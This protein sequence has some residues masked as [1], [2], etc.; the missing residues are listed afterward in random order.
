[1]PPFFLVAAAALF[2][3][4]SQCMGSPRWAPQRAMRDSPFPRMQNLTGAY[5]SQQLNHV[6]QTLNSTAVRDVAAA[7][8]AHLALSNATGAL[9]PGVISAATAALEAVFAA[10][11]AAGPCAGGWPWNFVEAGQCLDRNSVQFVSLP[12]LKA[13]V[14]FGGALGQAVLSRWL[15]RLQLAAAASFAEGA[16][17]AQPFYTNIYSMRLVNLLLFAQVTGNATTLA[18]GLAALSTWE[19]LLRGAGVHEYASPT[20][21]AVALQNLYAGAAAVADA[22]VARRLATLAE[23]L[24]QCSAASL[25][26]GAFTLAGAHSRDYDFLTGSGPMNWYYALSGLAAAA[27]VADAAADALVIDADPITQAELFVLWVRGEL[28]GASAAARALAAQPEGPAWRTA[29]ASFFHAA[30]QARP[31]DG[32][33]ATL[34]LGAS[35]SLGTSSL[36]YCPQDKMVVAALGRP[37]LPQVSLVQDAYDSPYGMVKLP[38]GSGHAKPDHLKATVAAVQDGGLAL[39]LNDLTMAI[40]ATAGGGP[41]S[42]LAANV[43]FPAGGAVDGVY[44]NGQRLATPASSPGAPDLPLP[45]G[46]TIAVRAGGGVAAFRV[47][48]ADGLLGFA[49]AAFLKFDGPKGANVGRLVTY[50]YRGPNATFPANPPPSRSLLLLGVAPGASDEEAAAVSAALAALQVTNAAANA[51][52]WRVTVAPPRAASAA[53]GQGAPAPGW[54]STLEAAMCV[55]FTKSILARRVNGSDV[56][57]P[58]G[59]HLCVDYSSGREVTVALP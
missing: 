55:P 12:L 38:D 54:A 40:E 52:N 18:Q 2:L 22:A 28:P 48:F 50:L 14:H 4:D 43:L 27:G 53:A 30:G 19:A 8:W 15:P 35:V 26:G 5:V 46:A 20:Y 1:M 29:R 13:V 44:L 56:R 32:A 31:T 47:P 49:P 9:S 16:T 3:S 11:L 25:F 6:P 10:Q 58:P 21:S 42:S 59:G 41:F 24:S 57:I 45:L 17:E 36:Y 23:Y 7:A 33:D 37:G 34:F 51:S 39:V